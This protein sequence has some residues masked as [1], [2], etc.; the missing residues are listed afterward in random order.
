MEPKEACKRDN[1]IAVLKSIY[2][3]SGNYAKG[4]IADYILVAML[5]SEVDALKREVKK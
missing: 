1:I 2:D 5:Q 3:I 4:K